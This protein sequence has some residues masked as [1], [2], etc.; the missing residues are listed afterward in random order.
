[1]NDELSKQIYNN[2]KRFRAPSLEVLI[3]EKQLCVLN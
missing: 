1:M 2:L 3:F